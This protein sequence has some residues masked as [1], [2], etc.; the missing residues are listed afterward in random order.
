MISANGCPPPLSADEVARIILGNRTDEFERLRGV[1]GF[2]LEPVPWD[3][4][5]HL[6]AENTTESL[7]K[8]GRSPA[9]QVIYWRFKSKA[10]QEWSSVA[11]YM[12]WKVFQF[13]IHFSADGRKAVSVP[14]PDWE[15]PTIVW[16]PNDFPYNYEAD[17]EHHNIWSTVPLSEQR[18][19]EIASQHREGYEYV[20]FT[21]PLP[22]ASIPSVWHSHVISRPL[23]SGQKGPGVHVGVSKGL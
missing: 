17:V 2:Q 11:D 21:N 15:N 4:V 18:V 22:L 7:G 12:L 13:P 20:W 6:V 23:R 5:K 9:G 19:L 14:A 1:P 16:R 10:D 8:L 3:T